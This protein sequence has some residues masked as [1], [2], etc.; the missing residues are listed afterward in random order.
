M[1]PSSTDIAMKI[2]HV[3]GETL[4][5]ACDAEL[6]GRTLS[7]GILR[8]EVR[9]SFYRD[10]LV[11]RE[12]LKNALKIATIANLVGERTVGVALEMGCVAEEN[13]LYIEGVPHAQMARML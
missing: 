11:D 10:V 8:L 1:S 12:S 2:Y 9:E 5:A 4:L 13:V 7:E 3:R 6:L